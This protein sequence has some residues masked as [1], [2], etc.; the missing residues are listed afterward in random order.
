MIWSVDD[1]V[2]NGYSRAMIQKNMKKLETPKTMGTANGNI[3]CT[4]YL[5]ICGP[6][7]GATRLHLVP[8]CEGML[9]S[10]G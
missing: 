3:P 9:M 6:L 10:M 1:M 8:E 5:P 2:A 4:H 7:L